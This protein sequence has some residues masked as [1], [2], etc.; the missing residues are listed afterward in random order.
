M[1]NKFIVLFLLPVLILSCKDKIKTE[2]EPNN[3]FSAANEMQ[4]NTSVEGFL[5]SRDDRDFYRL[6]I[7]GDMILDV[8]ITGIK[9]INHCIQIWE[10]QNRPVLK[11]LIDDTRKSSPERIV[12]FMARAGIYYISVSHGDRDIRKGNVETPYILSVKSRDPFIEEFEPNDSRAD[13]TPVKPDDRYTGYFS[14]AYNRLN[15]N[16][17]GKYREEDWFSF[18]VDPVDE[19]TGENIKALDVKLSGVKGVNSILE[20]YDETGNLMMKSDGNP[21]GSGESIQGIGVRGKQ[22]LYIMVAADYTANTEEP[23]EISIQT[24][25]PDSSFELELNNSISEANNMGFDTI[26]GKISS[27][28]DTDYFLWKNNTTDSCIRIKLVPPGNI[29]CA[30]KVLNSKKE[31]LAFVNNTGR[32]GVEICPC[33]TES[34][35]IYI[36]VIS[37]SGDYCADQ[38]YILTVSGFNRLKNVQYEKEDNNVLKKAIKIEKNIITGYVNSAGDLDYYLLDYPEST[39]IK[40]T[41]NV[42]GKARLQVSVTDPHGYT[43][44]RKEIN[45]DTELKI[46]EMIEKKGYIIIKSV[47]DD[48]DSSYTIKIGEEK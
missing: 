20:L 13:A 41:M 33:I 12:N 5:E 18:E 4:L 47:K 36:Q 16:P 37:P 24:R 7:T 43:I 29:D 23:Y 39:K 22:K 28:D 21:A 15:T 26:G 17:E 46:T 11:K 31:T 25:N 2:K 35:H 9:G 32:G 8:S 30:L 45:S 27:P 10:N 40:L 6:N 19:T 44:K 14:P 38:D 1:R 34:G 42:T 48:F 3:S